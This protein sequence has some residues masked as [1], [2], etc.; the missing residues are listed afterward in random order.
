MTTTTERP[1]LT[2]YV[3]REEQLKLLRQAYAAL[4]KGDEETANSYF[5]QV[6][7]IPTLAEW[8]LKLKGREYCDEHFNLY[9]IKDKLDEK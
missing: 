5:A 1:S 4:K 7:L 2:R 8:V 3:P 6:P 9:A